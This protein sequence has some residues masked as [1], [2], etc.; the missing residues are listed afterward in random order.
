MNFIQNIFIIPTNETINYRMLVQNINFGN[1]SIDFIIYFG[2]T[3]SSLMK[4]LSVK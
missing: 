3:I 4:I 2:A 1:S